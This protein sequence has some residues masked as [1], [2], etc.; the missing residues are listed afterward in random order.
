M[1]KTPEHALTVAYAFESLRI[2]PKN[3]TARVVDSLRARRGTHTDAGKIPSDL[4]QHE[5]HAQAAII[6]QRVEF[7]LKGKPMLLCAVLAEYSH[8]IEGAQAIIDLSERLA[9]ELEGRERLVV[10]ALVLR[11]FRGGDSM[12]ELAGQFG[13]SR[14]YL[15]KRMQRHRLAEQIGGLRKRAGD[16]LR[17][18][19]GGNG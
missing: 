4:S 19:G 18:I 10:D 12:R 13:V 17:E 14:S 7:A 6:R 8:G 15:E 1:F 2:E 16:V 5:W 3:A 9:P 11:E